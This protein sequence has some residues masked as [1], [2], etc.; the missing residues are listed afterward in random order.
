MI[1]TLSRR[2]LVRDDGTGESSEKRATIAEFENEEAI[3]VLGDPGMG[4]TTLFD[5]A[6]R[7]NYK[8]VRSFLVDPTGTDGTPLFLDALDEFRTIA[9][10]QDASAEVAKAL[11]SLNKPKF[12]LSCR[13]ADWFGSLDQE[14]I[15]AASASGRVVILELC[16]LSRAEILNAVAK[17]VPDPATFF[18]EVDLSGL[19]KLLGNPQTLELLARAWGTDKKPRNKFDAYDIGVSELLKE[20]NSRRAS[21]STSNVDP[22]N[23]RRAAGASASTLLLSNSIGIARVELFEDNGYF[24]LPLV[25]YPNKSDLKA[26]LNR[27]IFVSPKANHFEFIHRTIAEFL[28][29]EDLSQRIA[30]GLPIDR[31]MALMCGMDG[32]PVSSLRG[33]FAWLMCMLGNQSRGYVER[34]PYGVVTYGDASVLPPES[35]FEIWVALRQLRDPWFLARDED[36]GTFH[37]LANLNTGKII[38]EILQ[39]QTSG[40]HLKIAALESVANSSENIGV[41]KIIRNIVLEKHDNIW[42]RST[43]LSAFSNTVKNDRKQMD[44]LDFELAKATDDGAA[45]EVR[46]DLLDLTREFDNLP[47]RILSIIEQASVAKKKDRIIGRLYSLI[48]LPYDADLDEILDGASRIL[49]SRNEE[50]Y[51]IGVILDKWLNRRLKIPAPITPTQL[52]K[53]LLSIRSGRERRADETLASLKARFELEPSLFEGVFQILADIVPNKENSFWLFLFDDL[54]KLLPSIVWPVPQSEFFLASAKMERDPEKAADL[55]RMYLNLFPEKGA[56]AL[57]TE[58]GLDFMQ[59]RPDVG[60]ELGHWKSCKIQ[61]R[62]FDHHKRREKQRRKQIAE[63]A[64]NLAYLTPRILTIREGREERILAWAAVV[65]IGFSH[66]IEKIPIARDRLVS[67]TNDEIADAAIQGF[68]RYAEMPNI[69]KKDEIIKSWTEGKIPY[70]HTLLS[71]SVFFR[72]SVGMII[73]E[74]ALPHCL[75]AVV[76]GFHAGENVSG[77]DETLKAWF[78]RQCNQNP[79]IVK[80][81]LK[82]LWIIAVKSKHGILPGFYELSQDSGSQQFLASMSADVLRAGI[83]ENHNTVRELAVVLLHH[84]HLTALAIGETELPRNELSQE[85][86]TIWSTALFVID[87]SKYLDQWRTLIS[88]EKESVLWEAILV[89]R[90][91]RHTKRESINLTATQRAEVIRSLGHR[92]PLVGRLS[93]GW[94]D[95]N[96][97]DASEFISDQISMLAADSSLDTGVRL[98]SLEN[99]ADLES[100]HDLIRHQRAQYEKQQRESSFVFANPE[101]VAKVL[102]NGAPATPNDLLAFIVDHL[103]ALARDMCQTPTEKYRAYWN[104]DGRSLLEPK[105]EEVC[106]GFLAEDLQTRVHA[107]GLIVTVEHHMV[108]D[109]E[110]DLMVLQGADRLL[111]IEVKHHYHQN[112]WTAWHTQLDRL[113][114]RDAKTG[115]LGI[116]LVLWSGETKGRKMPKLPD[117]IKQRPKAAIDLCT[118][119]QTLVP[120]GDRHRLRIVVVD[121]YGP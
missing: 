119:I 103:H 40:N 51:E 92:F 100:Y 65:Y 89:I 52:S 57:L 37:D 109:K 72:H 53:W 87:S 17:M 118:A 97:Y 116:Y 78:I 28:A 26:V 9:S 6:S 59:C 110:C 14:V 30:A 22:N 82:K 112:L 41:S 39:D 96:P 49:M 10:G 104:E 117:G 7:G 47:T 64:A 25:P 8:A 62:R 88:K 29:A 74:D 36:R 31:V 58:A 63:H 69:P 77:Y 121:I 91:E 114:T 98:E 108:A 46:I 55:F 56:S 5:A 21:I 71:L 43:A 113:Y 120:E 67:V 12:R 93:Q 107:H 68:I 85:V 27:R 18:N 61:K 84:D 32:K 76:T 1:S 2:L 73:P 54:W 86:R 44:V 75:A 11:C 45:P 90:G 13:S 66:E 16:P 83:N 50:F 70:T 101:R 60:K 99:E 35:Q 15:K 95:R 3:V 23:L 111:P 80:S 38:R 33:L 34:D 94:G 48:E 24:H 102:S 79:S 19:G 42:L 81:V 20:T 4:K 105:R 115:G 106:S